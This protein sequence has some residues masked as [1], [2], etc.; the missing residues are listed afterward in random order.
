MSKTNPSFE[1]KV[2]ILEN[3]LKTTAEVFE[4]KVK[5]LETSLNK[6]FREEKIKT[7]SQVAVLSFAVI[8][9]NLPLARS[10]ST[11]F[12]K[13]WKGDKHTVVF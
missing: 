10:E 3:K 6:I 8:P 9:L 7:R 5:G 13:H 4:N 11:G 12:G 1:E 2:E